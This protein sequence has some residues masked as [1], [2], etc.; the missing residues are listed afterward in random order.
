MTTEERAPAPGS[1]LSSQATPDGQAPDTA[2][3]TGTVAAA[4][5]DPRQ[6]E[7]QVE[8]T[9]EQLGE[10]VQELVYRVDVKSR[11]QAKATEL[12]EKVKSTTVRTRDTVW[13]ARARW[14]PLAAG[15]AV[16]VVGFW[17]LGLWSRRQA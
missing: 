1:E 10:T 14:M 6:L 4:P 9:R 2:P 12:S 3:I 7:L 5:A 8:R 17:A 11:A 16:L 15:A 13:E